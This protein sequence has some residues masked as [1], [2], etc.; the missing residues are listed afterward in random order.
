MN[1][2]SGRSTESSSAGSED[3][4]TCRAST[5]ADLLGHI[6]SGNTPQP[7]ILMLGGFGRSG[8]TLLE[9]CLAETPGAVGIG[10]VLHLW[11]RALR[12]NELCGCG[13]P[14]RE[15]AFWRQI[16]HDAFGGWGALDGQQMI[17]DRADVVRTRYIPQLVTGV[18]PRHRRIRRDRFI[19][20]LRGLYSVTGGDGIDLMIDSSKHPAYAYLL[21]RMRMPLRCV[22]VVR[23]PRGVAYSW[24]KA[25]RRPEASANDELMPRYSALETAMKWTMYG[26]MFHL[27]PAVGVP[28][29]TVHYEDFMRNPR[30]TLAEVLRFAGHPVDDSA[31]AHVSEKSVHL[32]RHHTVAGNPM[33][34]KTGDVTLVLDDEW[35]SKMEPLPRVVVGLVTIPSRAAYAIQRRFSRFRS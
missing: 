32:G 17:D 2:T 27:L 13:T 21:R 29:M 5:R 22:L 24:S 10:E 25:V 6:G 3:S 11:E 8:S 19:S 1:V 20:K 14:F 31:L 26:W 7:T 9:R 4:F 12:D 33:R 18:T 28:T 15:C 23:D 35:K 34:F 30:E 16:G